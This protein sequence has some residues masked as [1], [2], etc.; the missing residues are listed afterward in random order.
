MRGLASVIL[1]ISARGGLR[2]GHAITTITLFVA[3]S[4][5][6][7]AA[8]HSYSGQL[9]PIEELGGPPQLAFYATQAGDSTRVRVATLDFNGSVIILLGVD[10]V[11]RFLKEQN[12]SMEG[13]L[14]EKGQGV[15]GVRLRP[16]LAD[17]YLQ[18][19]SQRIAITGF[20]KAPTYL[21]SCLV[22]GTDTL[23]ALGLNTLDAYLSKG[24]RN[25]TALAEAPSIKSLVRGISNEFF[26]SLTS[27]TYLLYGMLALASLVQ[28]Y[29]ASLEGR[30]LFRVLTLLNAGRK[31][32]VASLILLAGAASAFPTLLGYAVGTLTSAML[33]SV[34]SVALGLPHIKPIINLEMV[35][36]LTLAFF[37][38]FTALSIGFVKGYLASVTRR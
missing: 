3:L 6:L 10:D 15:A 33:S 31:S 4:V 7:H 13:S 26:Q 21:S 34:A 30:S 1:V 5:S 20:I 2:L 23:E 38:S 24:G 22:V 36:L 35:Y 25:S 29:T 9:R 27:L 16:G 19:N 14:P 17:N 32:T 18:I 11:G 8:S 12:A 28:G 37:T